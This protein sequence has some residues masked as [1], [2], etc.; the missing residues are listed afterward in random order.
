MDNDN[1]F[2]TNDNI[3]FYNSS[4]WNN[5]N[6]SNR[7]YDLIGR[8]GQYWR[9]TTRDVRGHEH[10]RSPFIRNTL[11]GFY[12]ERLESLSGET[13]E[14]LIDRGLVVDLP[15]SDTMLQK[16]IGTYRAAFEKCTNDAS[17]L[18]SE[19]RLFMVC[20]PKVSRLK[21]KIKKIKFNDF[22]KND[23]LLFIKICLDIYN[24]FY[25]KNNTVLIPKVK[26]I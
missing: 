5:L 4:V 6:E 23:E 18:D 3:F 12:K 7:I 19:V 1:T 2:Q 10:L 14:R 24:D 16:F 21:R 13:F 11:D 17:K 15:C 9:N 22:D 26:L 25:R 8:E 20:L